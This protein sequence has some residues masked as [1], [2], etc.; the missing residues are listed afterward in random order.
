MASVLVSWADRI[1]NGEYR[2]EYKLQSESSWTLHDELPPGTISTTIAGLQEG[3]GYDVRVRTQT[4]YATTEYVET[5]VITTVEPIEIDIISVDESSIEIGI[6]DPSDDVVNYGI[7]RSDEQ[8][9]AF[10]RPQF[11][12][13]SD[14]QTIA[15]ES[16]T[17]ETYTYADLDDN[18][19]YQLQIEREFETISDTSNI[20]AARTDY[21]LMADAFD[22]VLERESEP[23]NDRIVIRDEQLEQWPTIQ[24]E[25][26][27]KGR[28]RVS[29]PK[30]EEM[31]EWNFA[32]VQIFYDKDIRMRG[33]QTKVQNASD[34]ASTE[35]VGLDIIDR[36]DRGTFVV[37]IDA[38]R[39]AWEVLREFLDEE[40]DEFGS[41]VYEPTEQIIDENFVVIDVESLEEL[42]DLFDIDASRWSTYEDDLGPAKQSFTRYAGSRDEDT[43]FSL[44]ETNDNAVNNLAWGIST[45]GDA[46]FFDETI[47]HEIPEEEV[48]FKI[49][50]LQTD[51]GHPHEVGIVVNG[52]ETLLGATTTG[53][54]FSGVEAF[55]F[56]LVDEFDWDGGSLS[57]GDEIQ[58][59][60]RGRF[61]EVTGESFTSDYDTAVAL[62][63]E[64][65][66]PNS[67]TVYESDPEEGFSE[68]TDYSMDYENGEITVLSGGSMDD[69][70]TYTIDYE[71]DPS[72][73]GVDQWLDTLS[74]YDR[75]A[76]E[77]LTFNHELNENNQLAGPEFYVGVTET[78]ESFEGEFNIAQADVT[79]DIDD[80]SGD[81]RL[82]A[83]L[84][85]DIW[86]PDDGTE[87]NTIATTADFAANNLFGTSV[88][89]RVT[90]GGYGE[91]PNQTPT[92]GREPQKLAA[93]QIAI[94][95]TSLR[96]IEDET[97][98]GS[99]WGVAQDI[100]GDA[101]Y[102]IVPDYD[103]EIYAIEAFEPGSQTRSS[104]GWIEIDHEHKNVT[105][106]YYNAITVVGSRD[107]ETDE[108]PQVT[109]ESQSEIE[110]K[111]RIE[112][113]AIER[114]DLTS[115]PQLISAAQSALAEG[116]A[117]D[118]D[119][120]SITIESQ[121]VYPGYAYEIPDEC[122]RSNGGEFPDDVTH[123][124]VQ[125]TQFEWGE[126][127]VD[128]DEDD[129]IGVLRSLRGDLELTRR[130]TR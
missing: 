37:D 1:D 91:D 4:E 90:L 18:R 43:G 2:V 41:T 20:A 94:D 3:S 26:D 98:I 51:N 23:V 56:D 9:D 63:N 72:G 127:T 114:T 52:T 66:D 106:G 21:V 67:E 111:G 35:L 42:E 15:D 126:M 60:I 61:R 77:K 14:F 19:G 50:Y 55:W 13:Y 11:G 49:R 130:A 27:G 6:T 16:P 97:Y 120:G 73:P 31:G 76:E 80:I 123:L 39:A 38:P 53:F 44:D 116:I 110:E 128:F 68:G 87:A 69:S 113:P 119:T 40:V 92:Q 96:V 74:V 24:P 75:R 122:K 103:P 83:S 54:G 99:A 105:E 45:P 102:T 101:G 5:D 115:T 125:S 34:D 71:F 58:F 65:I 89:G 81:Q 85:G 46:L 124:T 109:V 107:E 10:G 17:I 121:L 93:Y 32:D 117:A 104:D 25:A 88:T 118:T 8:Q 86:L 62:S 70:T 79:A 82:Q 100:A 30:T 28:W 33:Q 59:F 57:R 7:R 36:L 22:V 95:T 47:E 12:E 29:I 78:A 129:F 64:D 112:G 84:D 108:L 48:G